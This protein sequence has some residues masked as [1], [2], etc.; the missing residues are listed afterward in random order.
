M[1]IEQNCNHC[2]VQKLNLV[3]CKAYKVPEISSIVAERAGTFIART[4]I[5]QNLNSLN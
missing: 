4:C 1:H 5:P 3:L 2:T